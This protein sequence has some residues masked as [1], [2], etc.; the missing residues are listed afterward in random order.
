MCDF[1]GVSALHGYPSEFFQLAV[2]CVA[3]PMNIWA[4]YQAF[5]D[6]TALL[7]SGK[8]GWMKVLAAE[9]LYQEFNRLLCQIILLGVGVASVLLPPPPP[10]GGDA[11]LATSLVRIGLVG[12]TL[13]MAHRTGRDLQQKNAFIRHLAQQESQKRRLSDLGEQP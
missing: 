2:S 3:V 4:V 12:V 9:H 8:N 10:S 1:C 13:L 11:E 7:D 6:R 5:G